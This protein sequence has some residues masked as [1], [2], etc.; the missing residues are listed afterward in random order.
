MPVLDKRD[1]EQRN[2]VVADSDFAG[3][4][5]I[6]RNPRNAATN[7]NVS[8]VVVVVVAADDVVDDYDVEKDNF[9]SIDDNDDCDAIAVADDANDDEE[10]D[11]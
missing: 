1:E 7:S 9:P 10:D 6:D 11:D 3:W 5:T 8:F 2:T 4:R